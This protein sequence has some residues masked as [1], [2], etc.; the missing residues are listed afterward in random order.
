[1]VFFGRKGKGERGRKNEETKTENRKP[2]MKTNRKRYQKPRIKNGKTKES[3]KNKQRT[4]R[5]KDNAQFFSRI[6]NIAKKESVVF[7]SSNQHRAG[8]TRFFLS[9]DGLTTPSSPSPSTPYPPS[10]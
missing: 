10:Y 2:R 9:K 4:N 3:K 8:K 5:N 1:V 6:Y 7:C